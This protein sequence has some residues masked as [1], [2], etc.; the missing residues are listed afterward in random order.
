MIFHFKGRGIGLL[1]GVNIKDKKQKRPK[2]NNFCF[3]RK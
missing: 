1:I 2:Q 3:S